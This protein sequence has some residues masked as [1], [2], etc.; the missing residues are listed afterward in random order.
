MCGP[1]DRSTVIVTSRGA[2]ST[3]DR[4]SPAQPFRQTQIPLM[5]TFRR[6][7]SNSAAVVPT[8]ETTRPQFGSSPAI[9]HL[10]RLLR[11]T[12]RPAC[13]A[14]SSLAAPMTSTMIILPAPSASSWSWRA[15]S[16]HT[17]VSIAVKSA[18]SG[19]AP[20]APLASSST[21]SLVDM[22][23]SV[24]IRSN[25]VRVASRRAA[26][27]SAGGRSASVV[28]THSMVARA[29]ASIPAPLAMPPM[30]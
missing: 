1:A 23:P 17:S 16:V 19:A 4:S 7:G 9:A 14:S 26:S 25:E 11:A 10:S 8:A 2:M 22:Q 3:L 27:R 18:S 20:E 12:A 5:A 30:A 21:V 29:G 24:S 6:S 15:R 13:T 28:T